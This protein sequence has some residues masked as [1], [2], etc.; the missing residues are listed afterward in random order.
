[1]GYARG[2]DNQRYAV[3]EVGPDIMGFRTDATELAA[4]REI[5][6]KTDVVQDGRR[7]REVWRLTAYERE[8]DRGREL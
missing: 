1:M 8:R 4:G 2:R 3:V 6:A 5:L 7:W